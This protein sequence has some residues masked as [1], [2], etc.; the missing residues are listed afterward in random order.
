MLTRLPRQVMAQPLEHGAIERLL[1]EDGCPPTHAI[2]SFQLRLGGYTYKHAMDGSILLGMTANPLIFA[3]G[4]HW[5]CGFC[6]WDVAPTT[7]LLMDE[8]GQIYA[9][10]TLPIMSCAEVL[11]ESDAMEH[12]LL[13]LHAIWVRNALHVPSQQIA[14]VE[15]YLRHLPLRAVP[16]ACDAFETWW[17]GEDCAVRTAQIWQQNVGSSPR[18]VVVYAHTLERLAQIHGSLEQLLGIKSLATPIHFPLER[19]DTNLV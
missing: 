5:F 3:E 12:Y 17:L 1:A 10:E 15:A 13:D 16:E 19:V 8:N 6:Q 4:D 18:S 9:Y 11:I 2:V 7:W 14:E